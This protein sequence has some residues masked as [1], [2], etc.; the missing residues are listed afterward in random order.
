[1][2]YAIGVDI[3]G[4]KIACGLINEHGDIIQ[5]NT[6]SSD[7]TDREA[8][9]QQVISGIEEL[10]GNCSIPKSEITGMGVGI[11]GKVD[12]EQGIAIFQ[13]NLPWSRFPVVERLKRS[14]DIDHIV[15]DNDV[16]MA[17]YA[18]W[19]AK[20]LQDELFVYLTISTGVSSAI[21]QAGEF[22]R[23]AGFA[24]EI[25]LVP[26]HTPHAVSPVTRLEKTAAGPA[27]AKQANT[28]MGTNEMNGEK[29]FKL[30]YENNNQAKEVVDQFIDALA[31]GVYIINSLLDPHAIVFGGSVASYNPVILDLLKQRLDNYMIDEQKHLLEQLSIS[32]L[33]TNQGIIGAGYR[34]FDE[35]KG[36]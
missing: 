18:E 21:I 31:Q 7:P 29:L 17:A 11:P 35:L 12:R 26:I 30:Y 15:V 34:L 9:F 4:T 10:L 23:G 3:G 22:I 32:K 2:Q 19:K 33:G 8:M 36:K 20:Q 24:G 13:N 25:G 1:M 28:L 6:V 5:Q 14:F 27:L 16:Y